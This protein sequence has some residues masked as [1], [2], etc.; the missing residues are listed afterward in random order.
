[1]QYTIALM[2]AA[3]V[4]LPAHAAEPTPYRSVFTDYQPLPAEPSPAA[5]WLAANRKVAASPA[6]GMDH[7]MNNDSQSSM[8]HN[9][10]NHE[11]MD[12]G[13]KGHGAPDHRKMNHSKP[14]KKDKPHEHHQ[15]H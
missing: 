6:H 15:E 7:S 12:H 10:M 2:L 13:A 8:D 5:G 14:A 11:K 1:M 9:T 4:M 3:A